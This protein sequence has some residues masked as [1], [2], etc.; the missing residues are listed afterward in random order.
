MKRTGTTP[1]YIQPHAPGDILT[2]GQTYFQH[3]IHVPTQRIIEGLRCLFVQA[4]LGESSE[5][6]Q[7]IRLRPWGPQLMQTLVPGDT[8][9]AGGLAAAPARTKRY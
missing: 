6:I 2:Q 4:K 1:Y 7:I 8:C 3:G 5:V 9:F